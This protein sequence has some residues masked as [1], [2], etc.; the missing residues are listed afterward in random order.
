MW[1]GQIHVFQLTAPLVPEANRSL[2]Q[3][4]HYIRE[5]TGQSSASSE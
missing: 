4:G 3:I 5:I 2:R 1:P